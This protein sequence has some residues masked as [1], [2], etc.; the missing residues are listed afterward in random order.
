[1]G[2]LG[3]YSF[4]HFIAY[5]GLMIVIGITVSSVFAAIQVKRFGLN[6]N[7]LIILVSVCGLCGILGA[8]IL[9]IIVSFQKID[10]ARL[11]ELPYLASIMS[12]GFVFLG[13][14]IG[15][16]PALAFCRAKLRIPV[17]PY[18]QSCMGCLPVAHA[19]GRVGC[20]LVG[21][22]YGRPH[23]GFPSVTYTRSLY[24]PN[25]IP[26]FPVQLTEALIELLIGICLLA[27]S[28][29]LIKNSAMFLYLTAYSAAR[30]CLE[31]IRYDE[32]RGKIMG[33]STSQLLCIFLFF[34]SAF[35]F[36]REIRSGSKFPG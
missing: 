6:M 8:K 28:R 26:L 15:A 11:N 23:T 12:G 36:F 9:Y 19:F 17:Q 7:D 25:G 5:Y 3:F 14:V 20:F 22:C 18:I 10:L 1:M 13:G 16:L 32:I 31:Y 27:L 2:S 33:I 29:K 35:L 24:A 30:F 34:S 21:C 4:G